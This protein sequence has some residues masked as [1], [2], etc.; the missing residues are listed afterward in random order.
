MNLSYWF[1]MHA[2]AAMLRFCFQVGFVLLFAF[3]FSAPLLGQ[4]EAH[5]PIGKWK[6]IDDN[7]GKPRSIVE[8]YEKNGKIFGKIIKVINPEK[9]NPLCEKCT[10]DKKNKPIEGLEIV[11]DM[12]KDGKEYSGGKIL[13]PEDGKIYTCKMWREGKNLMVRGYV[14]FFFR[15]QKWLPAE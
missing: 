8:I 5:S 9:P 1:M 3:A 7:T 4:N 6:T 12:K 11:Y 2:A 15:T 13:N 14:S 10:G